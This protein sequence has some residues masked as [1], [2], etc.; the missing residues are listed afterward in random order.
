[1]SAVLKTPTWPD[2]PHQGLAPSGKQLMAELLQGTDARARAPYGLSLPASDDLIHFGS[3]TAN[4]IN[5]ELIERHR[6]LRDSRIWHDPQEHL[7]ALFGA[8]QCKLAASGTDAEY[9]GALAM[10]G[11]PYVSI[12]MDPD[13][14]GSGCARAATGQSHT[15]GCPVDVPL[16]VHARLETTRLRNAQGQ[17]LTQDEVDAQV[18]AIAERHC[19]QPILLHHVACSKTGL[20]APSEAAC[21]SLQRG[22]TAGARVVV[23]ASQGRFE[24]ADVRRWLGHGWAVIITGSKYFGAPPFCGATLLPQG[25]PLAQGF[26]AGPGLRARWR[27]ALQAMAAPAQRQ[28]DWEQALQRGFVCNVDGLRFDGDAELGRQGIL[29]FDLGLSFDQTRLLHRSLIARGFFIGQPVVAGSRALLRVALGARTPL[30]QAA[31]DLERLARAV[32]HE[33]VYG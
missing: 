9:T 10:G 1:M 5:P 26:A 7:R 20:Q 2:A 12:L 27:L 4:P 32:R 31:A 28:G 17:A 24:L 8:A 6:A 23:D 19:D 29:S 30:A 16:R 25:W 13:E 18:F 14:V 22:H 15:P 11:Q 33:R 3:C 21:L